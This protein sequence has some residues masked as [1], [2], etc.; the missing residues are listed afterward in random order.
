MRIMTKNNSMVPVPSGSSDLQVGLLSKTLIV[1][2]D[3]I[4]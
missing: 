3:V 2:R 1:A 4:G